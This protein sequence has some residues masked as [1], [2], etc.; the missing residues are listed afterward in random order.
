MN[1]EVQR[2]KP[3]RSRPN[4]VR[5]DRIDSKPTTF[6]SSNEW[7]VKSG[8]HFNCINQSMGIQIVS[9]KYDQ[10]TNIQLCH[11][12]IFVNVLKQKYLFQKF[13]SFKYLLLCRLV[14]NFYLHKS[15]RRIF[16]KNIKQRC[17]VCPGVECK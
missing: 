1:I 5:Q 11:A 17:V 13:I 12:E 4:A 9:S 15:L 3:T 14:I 6:S 8:C 16:A 10:S 2:I 7:T